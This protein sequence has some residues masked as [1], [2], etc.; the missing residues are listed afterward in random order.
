MKILKKYFWRRRCQNMSGGGRRWRQLVR[1]R[2]TRRRDEAD[3]TGA[4][5]LNLLVLNSAHTHSQ[6]YRASELVHK[7]PGGSCLNGK[8]WQKEGKK[9]KL[10]FWLNYIWSGGSFKKIKLKVF[11]II[12]RREEIFSLV[13][14][15][16]CSELLI[17]KIFSNQ[18]LKTN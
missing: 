13:E 4:Y 5:L 9:K 10:V 6:R 2:A 18:S 3:G 7:D 15:F 12:C 14:H 11:I 17:H 16:R 8:L 1:L